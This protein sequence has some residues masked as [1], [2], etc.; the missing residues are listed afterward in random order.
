[1]TVLRK[2]V[3]GLGTLDLAYVAW[4]V[5][6]TI[7]NSGLSSLWQSNA[8][9]GLSWPGL[10]LAATLTMYLAI[11]FCGITLV[12]QRPEFAWVNYV[13]FPF[14]VLFVLPTTFP[15]IVG[16]AAAGIELHPGATFTLV[17]ATELFRVVLV[18]SWSRSTSVA[19]VA[20]GV[21]T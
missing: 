12:L 19:A 14:R 6:G 20:S 1:M 11:A 16:L 7:N 13:L 5:F 3:I 2:S 18:R 8:A 21:A 10:Q 15:V 4:I 9:F 17:A